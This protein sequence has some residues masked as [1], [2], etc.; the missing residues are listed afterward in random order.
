MTIGFRMAELPEQARSASSETRSFDPDR[1]IDTGRPSDSPAE[2]FDPDK[3]LSDS[4]TPTDV[5]NDA[6]GTEDLETSIEK[7]AT[8][9]VNELKE[10][11]E[12]P[13]T[14]PDK[15]FEA[16]ELARISPEKNGGM[17]KEFFGKKTDL[18][19]QWE[20]VNGREWPKYEKDVVNALGIVVRKAGTYYDMHHIKPLCLG[21][22]NEVGNVTPLHVNKHLTTEGIHRKDGACDR[23][24]KLVE[25]RQQ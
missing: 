20:E 22:K 12:V 9:Y 15:P 21:G 13:D 18:R 2:T 11:S 17:H 1:R 4:D 7:A 3:R 14:I 16:S 19:R 10:F 25:E 5:R 8:E 24:T 23:M 6:T